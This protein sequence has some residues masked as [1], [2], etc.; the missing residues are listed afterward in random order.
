MK[1]YQNNYSS[2]RL[3]QYT[4][5]T[6]PAL[7]MPVADNTKTYYLGQVVSLTSSGEVDIAATGNIPFGCVTVQNNI[8][9]A[10]S[11]VKNY[12]TVQ[13]L[14]NNVGYGVAKGGTLQPGQLVE[15]D[16]RN[17]T[18][19]QLNDYIVAASGTYASAIVLVGG[20][21]AS[22]VTILL[23]AAPVLIP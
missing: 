18:N 11:L 21:V 9:A 19:E 14:G 23:L 1:G 15:S 5:T 2:K 6:P 8:D 10:D 16:G 3:L 4:E 13:P 7:R 12:V 20:S 22:E 17:T